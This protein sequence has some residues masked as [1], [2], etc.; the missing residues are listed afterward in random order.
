M[1][2]ILLV[3]QAIAYS[4]LA[5]MP[6]QYGLYAA[7]LP[8]VL[9]AILGTSPHIAI[10][11]VAISA[12]LILAGVSQL[13]EPFSTEYIELVVLLGLLIG[14]FQTF[15]GLIKKGSLT[16]FLS[17]PVITGF[18]SAASIIIITSQLKDLL[19][20]HVPK[21]EY[22]HESV[23]HI[24]SNIQGIHVFTLLIACASGAFIYL[25][26]K[27]SRKIPSGLF[28]VVFGILF[29][30]TFDFQAKGIDIIGFVPSGLPQFNLPSFSISRIISLLPTIL[31]VS[32]IGIVETIG[33][34]KALENKNNFYRINSNQEFIAIGVAKIGGSFFNAL[35]SSASFSRSALLHQSKA[36]T[37]IA[38]IISVIFV[39]FALLYLT[40]LLHFLP[41]VILAVIIIY[42]IKNLFEFSLA[43]KLYNLF[44]IDFAV[45]IITFVASLVLSLEW[46]VG[47]GLIA[48]FM[49]ATKSKE[50]FL[51][52]VG[53]I[54]SQRYRKRI[55][56][57]EKEI[58]QLEVTINENLH[59]GNIHFLEKIITEKVDNLPN[60]MSVEIQFENCTHVDISATIVFREILKLLETKGISC[61]ASKLN[62]DLNKIFIEHK[63]LI[64]NK[65]ITY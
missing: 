11:P 15:I 47:I 40:P 28:L 54:F 13:A 50:S 48:S 38:S 4:Y 61:H 59:F 35:P 51:K 44:K 14:I 25:S 45:M 12:I 30:Y 62:N 9:Y 33:I 20:I 1:V 65:D 18:T 17:Y 37:N 43:K 24:I 2:A 42:A 39:I 63:V 21:F 3:P 16:N 6:P 41:K 10:G 58:S 5:G 57:N 7:I 22:F 55:F 29:S 23:I 34:A 46:G 60:I 19:G 49:V 64:N 32:T 52:G 53:T 36:K 26:N 8:I 31:L 27:L 56:I